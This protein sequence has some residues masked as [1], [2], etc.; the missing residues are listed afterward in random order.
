MFI[1]TSPVAS[2]FSGE[3]PDAM[4]IGTEFLEH[5]Q[6]KQR[7]DALGH[8]D[9]PHDP[10]NKNQEPNQHK[11]NDKGKKTERKNNKT[12]ITHEKKKKK[13]KGNKKKKNKK[14]QVR[15]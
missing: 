4:D 5:R 1:V 3:V 9:T 13:K 14:K 10:D 12:K 8:H 2:Q 7:L 6:H 11:K 15:K